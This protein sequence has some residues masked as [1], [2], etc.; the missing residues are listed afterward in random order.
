VPGRPRVLP[1]PGHTYGHTALHF[2]D[3]GVLVAGDAFVTYNPYTASSGPQIVSGGA[4]ADSA[5]AL[6]LFGA[7][8]EVQAEVTLTGHGPPW[9]RPPAAA[10]ELARSSG[11]S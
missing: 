10:V 3:R 2:E 4:T 1:T 6:A 9:R 8:E 11:P 7:L 5:L